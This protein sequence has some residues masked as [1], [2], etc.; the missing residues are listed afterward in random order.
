VDGP[1]VDDRAGDEGGPRGGGGRRE[2]RGEAWSRVA[3]RW[4]E[5]V[6]KSWT[7]GGGAGTV[8]G[9]G[10]G[11]GRGI[12]RGGGCLIEA[13]RASASEVD[14]A[15][16]AAAAG[17]GFSLAKCADAEEGL[18]SRGWSGGV[19]AEEEEEGEA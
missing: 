10:G 4:P 9:A 11:V 5:E 15:A 1:R 2:K 13:E 18:A 16:A 3:S 8:W 6:L 19:G 7:V 17:L 14:R 12:G